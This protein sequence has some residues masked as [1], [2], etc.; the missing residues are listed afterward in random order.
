MVCVDISL[1]G[2][3]PKVSFLLAGI[4]MF[5]ADGGEGSLGVRCGFKN[6]LWIKVV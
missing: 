1:I 3:D 5:L 6:D 2:Y 4:A